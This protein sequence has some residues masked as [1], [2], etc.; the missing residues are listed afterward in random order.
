MIDQLLT[1]EKKAPFTQHD[2]HFTDYR[3]QL[4]EKY[5]QARHPLLRGLGNFRRLIPEGL[6]DQDDQALFYM[7]SARAYFQGL[8]L[9]NPKTP[10]PYHASSRLQSVH[11]YGS[12]DDRPGTAARP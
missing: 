2:P 3:V 7:A 9:H 10:I 12:Y 11:G 5:R 8:H 1:I 6:I 4:L